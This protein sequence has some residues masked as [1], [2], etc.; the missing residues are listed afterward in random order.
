[1]ENISFASPLRRVLSSRKTLYARFNPVQDGVFVFH[2]VAYMFQVGAT[3]GPQLSNVAGGKVFE[4]VPVREITGRC[5]F[6]SSVSK[7][8]GT[9]VLRIA[10]GLL[11]ITLTIGQEG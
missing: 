2:P 1:M 8:K 9:Q 3:V 11:L 7:R 6:T 10:S 5:N 4:N